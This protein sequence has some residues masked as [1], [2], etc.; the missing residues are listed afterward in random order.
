RRISN[1]IGQGRHILHYDFNPRVR[2]YAAIEV[3]RGVNAIRPHF[4]ESRL[5]YIFN[6]EGISPESGPELTRFQIDQRYFHHDDSGN[7]KDT[8]ITLSVEVDSQYL[9]PGQTRVRHEVRWKLEDPDSVLYS[10][11]HALE[12]DVQNPDS[13]P[14]EPIVFLETPPVQYAAQFRMRKH[15]LYFEIGGVFAD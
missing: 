1:R 7:R 4:E 5:P 8:R 3:Q 15:Y 2:Y 9:E 13:G 6:S 10:G 12:N 14:G 11:T